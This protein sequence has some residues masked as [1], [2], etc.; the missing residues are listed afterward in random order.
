LVLAGVVIAGCGGSGPAKVSWTDG[1]ALSDGGGNAGGAAGGGGGGGAGGA[2]ADAGSTGGSGGATDVPV[3]SPDGRGGAGTDAAGGSGPGDGATAGSG[4]SIGDAGAAGAGGAGAMDAA[5]GAA[6]TGIDGGA[7]GMGGMGGAAGMGGMGGTAPAPDMGPACRGPGE[8]CLANGACCSGVCDVQMMKCVSNLNRCSPE[9]AGCQV[10]TDCCNLSCVGSRCAQVAACTPDGM[11]CTSAD[12]CCSKTCTNGTC[13]PLNTGCK[14]AGNTC[15]ASTQC[16]SR[17]CTN[18]RCAIGASY[19]IQPGDFCQRNTDCCTGFCRIA[20]GATAGVCAALDTTGGGG[21]TPDG[22]V[23]GDCGGC[24]SRLCAPYVTGVKICQ[25][26]SGCRVTNNLCTVNKDCCGGDPTEV[27][28]GAGSVTCIKSTVNPDIGACRNPTGCQVR[29]NICGGPS[30]QCGVNERAA[31]CDCPGDPKKC[32]KAD[33]VGIYRCFGGGSKDCPTGYTGQA[34]C[35]VSYGER[36]AFSAEC[37][38]GVPCVPDGQGVLRCLTPPDGGPACVANAGRCTSTGDCCVGL[39][40]NIVPGQATGTCGAPPPPAP[41]PP[42]P[43]PDGGADAPVA[44]PDGGAGS[45]G[46]VD[47]DAGAN[48]D[49][50]TPQDDA[51][52]LPDADM[53]PPPP[54][55]A[56]PPPPPPPVCAQ[57]GQMCSTSV[58]CCNSVPCNAPGTG[59]PCAA[60]QVGCTC[61][62][63]E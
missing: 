59:L 36:C 46:P 5:G 32:C 10:S 12:A 19:C 54:P 11:S 7:A 17:L 49:G 50:A 22:I 13:Q 38:S 6:G 44:N 40:C 21:C 39:L 9:G 1:G 30:G 35:C 53:P 34:P 33:S 51:G 28:E 55:D 47:P 16:C 26:P 2:G 20:Q 4:G 23:C 45:D 60:G 8:S 56:D 25:P 41:P 14:T 15:T 31:C 63:I 29:G 61:Y 52:P 18:G 24:C 43:G 3:A 62:I 42:P 27:S 48:P 37:C 58:P 57:Y